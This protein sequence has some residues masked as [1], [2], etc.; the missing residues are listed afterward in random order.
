MSIIEDLLDLFSDSEE[1]E[2]NENI[3]LPIKENQLITDCCLGVVL[4]EKPTIFYD[5]DGVLHPNDQANLSC[6][7]F[8]ID[9][10]NKLPNVQLVM[11]SNWR[12]TMD[13]EY[14][15]RIFP[16]VVVERT[17]GFTPVIINMNYRRQGE[18][19]AFASHYG[20]GMYLCLD[21]EAELYQPSWERLLLIERSEGIDN[22]TVEA[23]LSYFH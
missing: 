16:A 18:V 1:D 20:I 8:L 12:E 6:V 22:N 2:P 19:E 14:F 17:V 7:D 9:I 23:V 15:E 5:V 10:I 4:G 3:V 13:K 21:D 11:I